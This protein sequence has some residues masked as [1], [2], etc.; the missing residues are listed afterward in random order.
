MFGA[1]STSR[2]PGA[3]SRRIDVAD[4]SIHYV[5]A[6]RGEPLVLLHGW[7]QHCGAWRHVIA[8]LAESH[9]VI[10]PDLRGLG[11]SR[12]AGRDFSLARLR[13]DLLGLLDGLGLDRVT[14]VGHDWG[15]AIGYRACLS[16]PERVRRFVA[17]GGVTPWVIEGAGVGVYLRSWHVFALGVP[18]VGAA[19]TDRIAAWALRAW[20]GRGTFTPEEVEAY[21][22][23]LR[24]R[25]PRRASTTET[26]SGASPSTTPGRA[27]A[28]T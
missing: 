25:G 19:A 8:P 12:T 1:A 7:P 24:A 2:P 26:S 20:R 11:G 3:T 5:E 10:A 16:A 28:C 14:L 18:R 17:L 4:A 22:A 15:S 21:V 13:D 6:G 23:P 9:R 27:V